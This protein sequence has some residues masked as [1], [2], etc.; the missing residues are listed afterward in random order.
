MDLDRRTL[1][2]TALTAGAAVATPATAA[3]AA[4]RRRAARGWDHEADLVVVGAGTGLAGALAAAVQG[5]K[6]LVL[7]KAPRPGG[8]TG[9]AGMVWSPANRVARQAGISDPIER[10]RTYLEQTARGKA[11]PG[12]IEAYLAE[13]AR[14]LDFIEVHTAIRFRVGMGPPTG[15][16]API[17]ESHP[18]WPG[19]LAVGRELEPTLPGRTL[20]GAG[21][22]LITGLVEALAAKG[23]ELL[24][25]TAAR[26]LIHRPGADGRPEVIGVL[27]ESGGRTIRV[28]ARRGVL[29]ATGGF[30]RNEEMK[31]HFLKGV[32]PAAIGVPGLDGDGIRM[33]QAL[34]ADLRNVTEAWW[35]PVYR[36]EAGGVGGGMACGLEKSRPGSIVVNRRGERFANEASDCDSFT[37]AMFGMDNRGLLPDRNSPAWLVFDDACRQAHGIGMRPGSAPLP[38]WVVSAPTLEAL[39]QKLGM[40]P[41]GLAETVR[42]F[43]EGALAG[44]DQR[45]GRGASA[46][47][48]AFSDWRKAGPGA[49][50]APLVKGPF[51]AAEIAVGI[52]STAGGIRVNP[53]GQALDPFGEVL[54][55][56]YA[57]G[58]NSGIGAPGAGAYPGGGAPIG[59]GLTFAM[60]AGRHAAGLEPWS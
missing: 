11:A 2:S 42:T 34:G 8:S 55:R 26:R 13:S 48:R 51:H 52:L 4:S 50:L 56:L 12:M 17:T 46:Y 19:G 7:E 54:P 23:G 30:D 39:A 45:F 3:A 58:A 59:A 40:D 6:V 36:A 41:A 1:L 27:A 24:T 21:E 14:L 16:P 53:Q 35:W 43:N 57:S 5:Q 47:D 60:V 32:V 20:R 22:A 18:D 15:N 10:A 38:E 25:G 44:V 37:Q 49:T 33:A 28:R 31:R 29:L 9:I